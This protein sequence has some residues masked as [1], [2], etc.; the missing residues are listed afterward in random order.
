M[1]LEILFRR[2]REG[3]LTDDPRPEVRRAR[4]A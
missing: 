3:G 2:L 4:C 1:K